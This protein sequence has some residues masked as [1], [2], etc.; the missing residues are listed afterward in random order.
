MRRFEFV[1]VDDQHSEDGYDRFIQLLRRRCYLLK[2]EVWLSEERE[3]RGWNLDT[4]QPMHFRV[5]TSYIYGRDQGFSFC[6]ALDLFQRDKDRFDFYV[7]DL[8]FSSGRMNPTM[9]SGGRRLNECPEALLYDDPNRQAKDASATHKSPALAGL[10]FLLR[11]GLD[12]RPK[13]ICSAAERAAE[14][15]RYLALLEARLRDVFL[16]EV[17]PKIYSVLSE[18]TTRAFDALDRYLRSRQ[19]RVLNILPPE[20]RKRLVERVQSREGLDV[21]DIPAGPSSREVANDCWS[22]RTL[23]PREIIIVEAGAEGAKSEQDAL[24]DLL[25]GRR[26]W[27]ALMRDGLLNHPIEL[28]ER[29]DEYIERT[30]AID[31]RVEG[32][33]PRAYRPL[34][35]LPA[36]RK[37]VE[38]LPN[39][40]ANAQCDLQSLRDTIIEGH[41]ESC[42]VEFLGPG[43]AGGMRVC[44]YFGSLGVRDPVAVTSWCKNFG[45]YPMDLG[46][47]SHIAFHN[48]R[49]HS[50]GASVE[51]TCSKLG[52]DKLW[53][54]WRCDGVVPAAVF[55]QDS[56]MAS[57]VREAS[58]RPECLW[59]EGFGDLARI[60]CGRYK[61]ILE[62]ASGRCRLRATIE[63]WASPVIECGVGEIRGTRLYVELPAPGRQ[64]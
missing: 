32:N 59:D 61:G 38:A 47:V 41:E 55:S 51:F 9:R 5:L 44:D 56:K 50:P 11:T 42:L 29:V 49:R 35:A 2:R 6:E 21:A 12:D 16:I 37:I 64:A 34:T 14:F 30:V 40:N 60:V 24:V 58:Q 28:K 10:S 7:F 48:A 3:S 62:F 31:F 23:F 19:A 13:F 46:Y 43:P 1:I 22:L 26:D 33:A 54:E 45:V 27:A 20:F 18:D 52:E 63:T 25:L 57:K 17:D 39:A 15:R 53:L 4:V 8:D 36:F